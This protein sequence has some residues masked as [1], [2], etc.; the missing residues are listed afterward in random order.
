[1]RLATY[2][3]MELVRLCVCEVNSIG[4]RLARSTRVIKLN[5]FFIKLADIQTNIFCSFLVFVNTLCL[6]RIISSLVS[7]RAGLNIR[8]LSDIRRFF[9]YL[10]S[11][12]IPDSNW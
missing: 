3:M 8:E 1:M 9:I 6:N 2:H 4:T 7:T 10:V 5:I 12:R 11:G